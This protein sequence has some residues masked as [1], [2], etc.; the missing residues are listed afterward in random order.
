MLKHPIA[1]DKFNKKIVNIK[2]IHFKNNNR[3]DYIIVERDNLEY[4]LKD[5]ECIVLE[6][7]G[8]YDDSEEENDIYDCDIVKLV[9]E[10]KIFGEKTLFGIMNN[11]K[12]GLEIYFPTLNTSTYFL[13]FILNKKIYSYKIYRICNEFELGLTAYTTFIK[14]LEEDEKNNTKEN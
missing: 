1:F 10:N 6:S 9:L 5:Y 12:F 4:K 13:D 11:D 3:I 14:K 7:L 2:S 8:L